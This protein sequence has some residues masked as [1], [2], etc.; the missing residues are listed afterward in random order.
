M[1]CTWTV[2]LVPGGEYIMRSWIAVVLLLLRRIWG[3]GRA[4]RHHRRDRGLRSETVAGG[5][6]A[7]W[8]RVGH[9]PEG[10]CFDLFRGEHA[11]SL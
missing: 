7:G 8:E 6:G 1:L 9:L 2:L 3:R 10:A 5:Q 4:R 11:P